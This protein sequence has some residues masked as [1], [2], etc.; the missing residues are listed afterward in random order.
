MESVSCVSRALTFEDVWYGTGTVIR[1][2]VALPEISHERS[3]ESLRRAG[4]RFGMH[5]RNRARVSDENIIHENLV[6]HS[7]L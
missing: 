7:Y 6:I 5:K 4:F 2:V 1:A 3:V